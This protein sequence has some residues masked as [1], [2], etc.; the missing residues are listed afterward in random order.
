MAKLSQ[1]L[2]LYFSLNSLPRLK[3][4][5]VLDGL[6]S[7]GE[8]KGS[9]RA[10]QFTQQR[11][12]ITFTTEASKTNV[13]THGLSVKQ[14]A[15]RLMDAEKNVTTVVVKD[16]PV[17]MKDEV[18]TTLLARYGQVVQGSVVRS[19]IKGTNIENGT[20]VIHMLNVENTIPVQLEVGRF[21]VRILCDNNKTK[22]QYCGQ[23]DHKYYNCP[24]KGQSK[25]S[26]ITRVF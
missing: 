9:V 2:T 24:D 16:A 21:T 8:Q 1:N 17:E 25:R 12:N 10:I 3:Y 20:R 18:L 13:K 14:R 6:T 15:V 7:V 19:T 26:S 23:T 4:E 11:C 5:E 22:C